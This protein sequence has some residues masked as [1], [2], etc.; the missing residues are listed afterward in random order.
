MKKQNGFH[1]YQSINSS[2]YLKKIS[3]KNDWITEKTTDNRKPD[4]PDQVT[5]IFFKIGKPRVT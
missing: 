1:F 5:R 3:L 2:Y 4:Q